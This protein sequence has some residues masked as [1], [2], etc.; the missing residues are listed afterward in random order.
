M[1]II[2]NTFSIVLVAVVFSI[3]SA[4][5][6]HA[7]FFDN[8]STWSFDSLYQNIRGASVTQT[9]VAA[10][11]PTAV[12]AVSSPASAK[13]VAPKASVKTYTVRVTGYSS[14]V[15]ETDDSPFITAKGT[16]VRDGVVAA[17]FLPFG[18]AIKIPELYGDKIFVVEDRMNSRYWMNVDIWFPSKDTALKF[19]AKNV[20]IE[21]V[22]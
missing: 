2:K 10:I 15:D 8:S 1:N 11:Q 7:G 18:T 3:V 5:Q 17:N 6:A 21:I 4:N 19:G 16:Y 13:T 22:S 20:K 12:A 9:D 14:S